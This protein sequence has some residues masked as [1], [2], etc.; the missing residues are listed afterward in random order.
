MGSGV[1]PTTF[2]GTRV[3]RFCRLEG[4]EGGDGV[5]GSHFEDEVAEGDVLS[6]DV[7]AS[8]APLSAIACLTDTGIVDAS[9]LKPGCHEAEAQAAR[10]FA[11]NALSLRLAGEGGGF[12]HCLTW[13]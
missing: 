11:A 1:S 2:R 6:S 3:L 8:T 10:A 12:F 7:R 4:P 5:G 9:S 13:H